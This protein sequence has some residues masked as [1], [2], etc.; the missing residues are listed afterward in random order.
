MNEFSYA[1]KFKIEK[2]GDWNPGG[3]WAVKSSPITIGFKNSLHNNT[4]SIR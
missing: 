1:A 2:D 3:F 4:T